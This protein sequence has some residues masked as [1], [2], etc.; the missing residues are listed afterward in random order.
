MH[1]DQGCAS[2]SVS[3]L[4]LGSA[5]SPAVW[6]SY[7]SGCPNGSFHVHVHSQAGVDSPLQTSRVRDPELGQLRHRYKMVRAV[8]K[9]YREALAHPFAPSG[10]PQ[11]RWWLQLLSDKSVPL[12]R[13]GAAHQ[14]LGRRNAS[15]LEAHSCAPGEMECVDSLLTPMVP[16]QPVGFPLGRGVRFLKA[17]MWTTL[18]ARSL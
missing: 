3:Y 15:M 9:L 18:L 16:R 12:A 14:L 6:R 13:C 11:R 4:F 10:C 2:P 17:D 1:T 7:L 5:S 8:L